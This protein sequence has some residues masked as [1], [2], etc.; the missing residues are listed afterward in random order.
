[1]IKAFI[2][3]NPYI[4]IGITIGFFFGSWLGSFFNW[5]P[6]IG[7]IINFISTLCFTILGGVMIYKLKEGKK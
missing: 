6:I 2:K 1:M 4:M 5:I 7:A 3:N